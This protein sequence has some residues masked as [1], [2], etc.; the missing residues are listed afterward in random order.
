MAD[1]RTIADVLDRADSAKPT[2]IP[3]APHYSY[4]QARTPALFA[5]TENYLRNLTILRASLRASAAGLINPAITTNVAKI[6][7]DRGLG[8]DDLGRALAGGAITIPTM[9]AINAAPDI[10]SK[11]TDLQTAVSQAKAGV[12][13]GPSGVASVAGGALQGFVAGG[14]Y[15]AIAG[16]V[17]GGIS[18]LSGQHAT[19]KIRNALNDAANLASPQNFQANLQK[20]TDAARE[21]T[22]VSGQQAQ[23]GEEA[24]ISEGG[25]RGT[26]IG[27]QASIGAA[28]APQVAA[29][30][31]AIGGAATTSEKQVA[32][33]LGTPVRGPNQT[34]ANL[35]LA[36]G[37]VL[38]Q[39]KKK[40]T[41]A[42][43][44]ITGGQSY[45]DTIGTNIDQP[46]VGDVS[47]V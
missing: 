27:T 30:R 2:K 26:G 23:L 38:S 18:A 31:S 20:A 46:T 45:T 44:P 40:K 12:G 21:Q 39:L 32:A 28:V 14:P 41:F 1:Q 47:G 9:E 24:A 3:A 10:A 35:A 43:Q 4:H 42:D 25:L 19:R 13:K 17:A 5:S 29:L 7:S 34:L 16:A 33:S 6:L 22:F 8:N 15:G 37:G 11:L 36:T